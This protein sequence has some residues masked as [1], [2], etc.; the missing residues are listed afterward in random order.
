MTV[1]AFTV[2]SGRPR[3]FFRDTDL[4]A[5]TARTNSSSAW[6]SLWDNV[7][8]PAANNYDD[9]A[10]SSVGGRGDPGRFMVLALAGLV[11]DNSTYRNKAI[12]AAIW[13]A[14]NNP[15]NPTN[16]S[17]REVLLCLVVVF[18]LLYDYMTASQRTAIANEIVFW[19]TTSGDAGMSASSNEWMDGH[20]GIDQMCQLA[21]ALA[22]HGFHS[23][24]TTLLNESMNFI[25]GASANQGRLEMARY[26][27]TAGGTEKGGT[28]FQLG[29]RAELGYLWFLD[30]GTN[31][32][33][34]AMED[35]WASKVW[36][37]VLWTQ[38]RGNVAQ[39]HEA[40]G[41]T[42]KVTSPRF[43]IELRWIIAM[44][45]T[46]FASVDSGKYMRWLYDQYDGFDSSFADSEVWGVIF[47]DRANVTSLAPSAAGSPPAS[48]KLFYPPGI[49][50]HRGAASGSAWNFENSV[51]ARVSARKWF[52]EGHFH[53]DAGSVQIVYKGDALLLAPAGAYSLDVSTTAHNN[54]ALQRSWLQSLCPLVIDP[55]QTYHKGT[56]N[57]GN[58]SINDGGQHYRKW[59][60]TSGGTDSDPTNV[61]R[62][63]ND[64]GGTAWLR[65]ESFIEVANNSSVYALRANI[66]NAY[67]KFNT[68]S[69]RCSVL[70]VKYMFIKPTV[71]NGLTDWAL[72]YYCRIVK[73]DPDWVT[74]IPLHAYGTITT[75]SYGAHW[76]GYNGVNSIS[77]AGKLW[78][79]IRNISD[80]TRTNSTP[81]SAIS[82]TVWFANQ[83]KFLGSGTNFLPDDDANVREYRDI[84]KH[85]LYV[86]KTTQVAE[87]RYV[88]LLM[89]TSS[90]ASEPATSR[91]WETDGAFP[92][93]YAITFEGTETYGWH[94]TL[95]Q[96]IHP[97]GG[98]APDTTPPANPTSLGVSAR[99]AALLTTW[100][101]PADSDLDHIEIWKRTSAIP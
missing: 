15:P 95:D 91:V 58:L 96:A 42:N 36:E 43:M 84:K 70:D 53:L 48:S 37:A 93:H 9:D 2:Y 28:Y 23:Q 83:F 25:Y 71:A 56:I 21:G 50:F 1:P 52:W 45:A 57:A 47:L 97:G 101:D 10:D 76:L 40:H 44:L 94:R 13:L 99:N 27:Y 31:L 85:S 3:V 60:N 80:Y 35:A 29:A 55:S 66:R 22:I 24:A 98:G 63:Q 82:G 12:T 61:I 18:D 92:N 19:C 26:Q 20:S 14:A 46:K 81:G 68:S 87:E 33:T 59:V 69:Q 11:E 16:A 54:N 49:A 62:M 88:F 34:W 30:N 86:K 77:P 41:D 38:Y 32:D 51:T 67:K 64:G 78:L 7:I 89:P 73:A 4:T 5:I 39:D 90:S 17:G 79:D 8:I 6:Q 65:C 100:V 75:T 72:L 74:T